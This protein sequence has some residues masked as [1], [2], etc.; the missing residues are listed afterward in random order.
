MAI[1]IVVIV[2]IETTTYTNKR[3][4]DELN[5]NKGE[6]EVDIYTI[7]SR[8]QAVDH[9]TRDRSL[10]LHSSMFFSFVSSLFSSLIICAAR[11]FAVVEAEQ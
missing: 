8:V 6:E 4:T 3:S 1:I 10:C 11:F 2:I 5:V 7:F 9:C